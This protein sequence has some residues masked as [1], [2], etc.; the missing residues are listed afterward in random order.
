M[1]KLPG[2]YIFTIGEK[3]KTTKPGKH[4]EPIELTAFEADP[5]LCLVTN[6]NHNI[7]KIE[8][9]QGS[10]SQLLISQSDRTNLSQTLP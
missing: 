7:A 9:L 6:L 1:K 2:K 5:K 8:N 3:L 4:L 10:T